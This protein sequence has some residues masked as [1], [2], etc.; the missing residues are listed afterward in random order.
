MNKSSIIWYIKRQN[1]IKAS[2][3]SSEFIF[4][5]VCVEH[6]TALR[7]KLMMFVVLLI[8]Y[9]K[10]L[11]DNERAVTNSSILDSTLNKNYSSIAYH[12]VRY[13]VT[14]GFINVAWIHTSSNLADEMTKSLT[15]E[16]REGIYVDW[17]Y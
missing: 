2:T 9:T 13:N 1:T 12:S 15:A 17:T 3:F 4:M 6:I 14:A 16:K 11:C 5:K 8:N 10:V 7:F